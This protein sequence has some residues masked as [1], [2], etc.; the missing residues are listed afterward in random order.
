MQT[1]DEN[2]QNSGAVPVHVDAQY[3]KGFGLRLRCGVHIVA[4]MI[5]KLFDEITK[6]DIN[7]LETGEVRE[8]RTIEYKE[9]LPRQGVDDDTREFLAD[10]S[11]FANA[12]GGDLIFG[13]R[14]KRDAAGKPTGLPQVLGLAA[15][16]ADAEILRL[17][18][19]VRS[20][21]D[22]RI[23]GVCLKHIDGFPAGSI[24]L[25]R[26]PRSWA[27]PHMVKF[28]SWTRFFS[29]T[30]AGKTELDVREI[31]AA[32]VASET[33][34]QKISAFRSYR[35][36][37][38][39]AG[40]APSPVAAG[41]KI[42]LHVLPLRGF[43]GSDAVD[44][45]TAKHLSQA[46][47][48][49]MQPCGGYGNVRFNFDGLIRRGS[50]EGL[51]EDT[52]VQLFRNGA[53]EAVSWWVNHEQNLVGGVL[54]QNTTNSARQYLDIQTQLGFGPPTFIGVSAIGV[55]DYWIDSAAGRSPTKIDRDVLVAPEV[56][57]D[58][59]G[60]D[61]EEILQPALETLWQA[62]GWEGG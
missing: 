27:S 3:A 44:I 10:V 33:F 40:E 30:S 39:L 51:K 8:G 28:K 59:V 2:R 4:R 35:I 47:L 57:V 25:L 61:V 26:V 29:R 31:R 32:F 45:K 6:E 12:G 36:G 14:D 1:P 24:I 15:V 20:S 11:S 17:E 7:A 18:Q 53:I 21:I 52:Y 34:T 19:M 37:K 49:P 50:G 60:A 41:P 16:N 55:K 42:L 9:Q 62:S 13:V 48:T 23:P 5:P 56:L 38:I 43:S 22:P 46:R 54:D 58:E